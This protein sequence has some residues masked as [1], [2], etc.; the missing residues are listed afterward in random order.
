MYLE[1][2]VE[3]TRLIEKAGNKIKRDE[4]NRLTR[5]FSYTISKTLGKSREKM[6]FSSK[7]EFISVLDKMCHCYQ[8]KEHLEKIDRKLKDA[9]IDQNNSFYVEFEKWN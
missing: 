1:K 6:E 3:A 2:I 5:Y 8:S 7:E 9:N 4:N